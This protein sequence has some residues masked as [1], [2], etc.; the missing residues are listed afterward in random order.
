MLI[1][2]I[3][4]FCIGIS[5]AINYT[6]TY[7]VAKNFCPPQS[8]LVIE[9]SNDKARILYQQQANAIRHPASL[10]KMMTVYML[11]EALQSKR[12]KP[13]KLFYVSHHASAQM[14]SKLNLKPG[15]Y[16]SVI[17][18][19]KALLVKSANDVAVVVAE[20]LAGS[21]SEFCR[22]MNMK[23][24]ALGMVSTHFENPS[25]VPNKRQVTT[26]NDIAKL[27][28]ALY[29]K[30]PQYWNYFSLKNFTYN[31]IH[32]GT[33]CKILGWYKGS[34]GA[35]TGFINASGFNLWVTARRYSTDGTPKRLFAVVFGGSSGRERDFK[36]ARLMDKF[37]N[38][39]AWNNPVSKACSNE[40]HQKTDV[41]KLKNIKSNT[42]NSQF[43]EKKVIK[44]NK[45]KCYIL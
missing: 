42:A 15:S 30:F 43:S 34:D 14:P 13:T 45:N 23:A 33:H 44:S 29:K 22:Q 37:F 31:K 21:V 2:K 41:K 27:G 10:T 12:I 39:Y 25:G 16:I 28:L 3:Q 19:V 26:A 24:K 36:A 38:G 18:C 6:C 20:G 5:F 8:A 1:Q 7:V 9:Y 17:D 35:K 40:K 11:L 32:Y 4:I